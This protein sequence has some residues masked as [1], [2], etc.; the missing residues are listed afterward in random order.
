MKVKNLHPPPKTE[1]EGIRRKSRHDGGMLAP[2][3]SLT[4]KLAV[5]A[6]I[7]PRPAMTSTVKVVS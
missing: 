1:N 4:E 5:E 2:S 7:G 6:G 3:F